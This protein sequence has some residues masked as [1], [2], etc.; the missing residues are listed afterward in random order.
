M[1]EQKKLSWHDL[2]D[3]GKKRVDELSTHEVP[4]L[5]GSVTIRQI[6]GAEQDAAVAAGRNGDSFDEHA[7][8]REQIKASLVDPALPP[9]EA[10]AILDNL[11]VKAFGQLQTIVQANS[12][13]LGIGVEQVVAMFRGADGP[14]SADADGS[15]LDNAEPGDIAEGVGDADAGSDDGAEGVP[16]LDAQGAGEGSEAT[17]E[18]A[19]AAQPDQGEVMA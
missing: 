3:V 7:V 16:S 10:D 9:D 14:G 6:S 11:P 17:G 2:V 12:G 8:A 13:L 5:G 4:A 15:A 18:G 1:T 19:G